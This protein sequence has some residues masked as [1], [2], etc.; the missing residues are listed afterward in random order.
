MAH[1][2]DTSTKIAAST[3]NPKTGNYICGSGTT[4]LVVTLI[5]ANGSRSG[6]PTYNGIAL[7]QGDQ[8]RY[9][10]SNP[11]AR[12]EAWFLLG[13]PT[14]SSYQISVPN[15][16][17]LLLEI[18]VSS[19]K[20]Q[21]GYCSKLETATGYQSNSSTNPSVSIMTAINGD[22]IVAVCASGADAWNP[23]G[24]GGTQLYDTD[25]DGW[26]GGH[27]Y[28][29]QA[30]AGAKAMSWTFETAD[31]WGICV[32]A[33]AEIRIGVDV[34]K[35]AA[36]AVAAPKTGVDVS[37]AQ[38]YGVAVPPRGASVAKSVTY[39][40]IAPAILWTGIDVSKVRMYV[41]VGPGAKSGFWPALMRLIR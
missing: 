7:T 19:Y 25:N 8:T 5:Y 34:S 6:A 13:P 16:N 35:A 17:G 1:T 2:F 15:P 23:T 18:C 27:Q 29:L 12:A 14:G 11:E 22:V 3:D 37:K 41:V 28:H 39:V 21:S 26:G 36:Y 40:A 33:F 32:L 4:V 9:A 10:A 30:T 38:A 20:A 31:D 24:W